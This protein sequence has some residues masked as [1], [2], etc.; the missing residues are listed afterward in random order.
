MAQELKPQAPRAT[1]K[2]G[3]SQGSRQI[4]PLVDICETS[5]EVTLFAQI[6]GVLPEN[7]H[8][9]FE[10]GELTLLGKMG[11]Q[12][13]SGKLLLDE[14]RDGD[15]YRVFSLHDTIDSGKIHADYKHGIL[16]IHLPKVEVAQPREIQIQIG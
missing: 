8:L 6:P 3:V 13:D 7:I 4:T 9:D 5:T 15:Y 14:I 16:A 2:T 11:P 1:G 10:K 12:A